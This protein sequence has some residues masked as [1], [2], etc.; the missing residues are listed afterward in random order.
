MDESQLS[1]A[2]AADLSCELVDLGQFESAVPRRTQR[3]FVLAFWFVFPIRVARVLFG[4]LKI[5]LLNTFKYIPALN[6]YE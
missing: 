5:H 1:T 6:L 3:P 2:G 4:K